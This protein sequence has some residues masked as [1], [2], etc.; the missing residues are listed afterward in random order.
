[1]Q[2]Q[3]QQQGAGSWPF[4]VS[5][6][7][8]LVC[9]CSTVYR[10]LQ[11][12]CSTSSSSSTSSSIGMPCWK[13][14]K[15]LPVPVCRFV[16]ADGD[17]EGGATLE[18]K[19]YTAAADSA[20]AVD[21]AA[22][23]E[24]RPLPVRDEAS[25]LLSLDDPL[26]PIAAGAAAALHFFHSLL[27]EDFMSS[28]SSISS[29]SR[30][31]SRSSLGKLWWWNLPLLSCTHT[32]TPEASTVNSFPPLLQQQQQGQQQKQRQWG[33][34]GSEQQHRANTIQKQ[35][36][37]LQQPSVAGEAQPLLQQKPRSNSGSKCPAPAAASVA[38]AAAARAVAA[39]AKPVKST[40][41]AAVPAAA[42]ATVTSAAAEGTA[43]DGET[44]AHEETAA[45]A[46]DYWEELLQRAAARLDRL[47]QTLDETVHFLAAVAPVAAAAAAAGGSPLHE[48]AGPSL[49]GHVLVV[50][51]G[52][53]LPVSF[54]FD[55]V[56][57]VYKHAG[58]REA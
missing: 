37:L 22:A 26:Q 45:A 47:P 4:W 52:A 16:E 21:S 58:L 25:T 44:A 2:R 7:R 18:L 39:A 29:S 49:S 34:S 10:H 17:R 28:S 40:A 11:R 32:P 48:A 38:V 3:Q 43:A 24:G 46:G 5:V 33:P 50:S 41:P 27:L 56:L 8:G 51:E 54:C 1:M 42:E 20:A 53:A 19:R 14:V 35:R 12:H 6:G 36:R 15:M 55:A 57:S 23:A 30:S 13:V 31:G 9:L